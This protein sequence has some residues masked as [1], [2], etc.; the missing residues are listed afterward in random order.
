M[1]SAL[2][3]DILVRD[4]IVSGAN[5]FYSRVL[6]LSKIKLGF[7]TFVLSGMLIDEFF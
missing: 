4:S 1:H 3:K 7:H 5:Y 2:G 6:V